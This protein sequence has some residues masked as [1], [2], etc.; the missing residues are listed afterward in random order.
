LYI[1]FKYNKNVLNF[2]RLVVA[3]NFDDSLI[4]QVKGY[5]VTHVFGSHQRTLTG[6]GRASF[7]LPEVSERRFKEH[8]DVVHGAKIKFLYTMNTATLHGREYSREF[9]ERLR[10]EIETLVN[11]GVDGFVVALP[12]LIK[13]IKDEHP[14]LEVS[15]SSYARVYNIREVENFVS[16]GADTIILHE[17]DNRNFKLL[18]SLQR[19][20]G[21]VD[22]ELIANNSCL[23][24]C[25]YRRTHDLI[26][27]LA[28]SQDSVNF[29]FEYP[30]LF[31]AT[32]V[33]NDIANIIRM[34]WI[35]PEDL[36]FYE[37]LG[38]DRFKI[39]GRNKK[40]EWLVRAVKAYSE[41]RYQGN[42]LDIVSYPQGR[43]TPRVVERVGGPKDYDVL[44][45]VYV[46]NSKF[47][48]KW[49]TF[50]RHNDCETR[51]C[52]DCGYCDAVARNVITVEGRPL[53]EL[54]LGKVEV[55]LELIQRFGG[56][57]EAQ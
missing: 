54:K 19:F 32:D 35:R 17:D 34:R 9:V 1:S 3:T 41:G 8:L 27:S 13:L 53:G 43:A 39:A 10:R 31:C 44:K 37:T 56:H 47:P 42:L 30:I 36:S 29:W 4:E 28:S 48:P 24:G 6:H 45:E 38:I 18:N 12:F 11:L 15:V 23:W 14:D 5:P 20:R 16:L 26:S 33:R 22:L 46:D 49:L 2:M 40:T 55:P 7:L 50:F 52:E 51:S 25:V 21:K 57:G